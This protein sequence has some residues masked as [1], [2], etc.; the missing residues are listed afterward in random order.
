MNTYSC[1]SCKTINTSVLE[2]VSLL[3]CSNC[4]SLV[5]DTIDDINKPPMTR[6]PE[7]WS[8]VQI[9]TEF[10]YN[11]NSL[12]VVGRIRLQLRNDYKNFWCAALK[13]GMHVWIMESFSSFCILG[14]IWNEFNQSLEHLLAGHVVQLRGD[15]KLR[16]EYVEKCVG[17][18]YEGEIG[19]WEMFEPGDF[20]VIQCSNNQNNTA[21]FLVDDA[22]NIDYLTGGKIDVEKLNLKNIIQ[23]D[24]WK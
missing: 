22:H 18:S 11:N 16:S 12:R 17:I 20:Y 19:K 24:E 6:V 2:R 3:I 9:G 23:W 21:V 15:L 7:D 8:Y 5:Y 10:E 13:D 14:S 4:K 1:P